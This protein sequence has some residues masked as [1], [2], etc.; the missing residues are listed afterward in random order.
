MF[1]EETRL[2]KMAEPKRKR[3]YNLSFGNTLHWSSNEDS[4]AKVKLTNSEKSK[5]LHQDTEYREK[6]LEG[7]KNRKKPEYTEESK[8]KKRQKM[9]KTMAEKFPIDNRISYESRAG[10]PEHRAKLG[11]AS[12]RNWESMSDEKKAIR[13]AKISE[14][15]KGLKNRLG[16]SNSLEHRQKISE[17]QKGKVLSEEH[18]KKIS[19]AH[20]GRVWSEDRKAKHS[21]TIQKM[22]ENK[23]LGMASILS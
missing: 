17:S 13:S 5:A 18:R 20:K 21:L 15:N 1:N 6:Y 19:K 9:V 16:H 4:K 7:I 14:S 3:Y 10:S 2:L 22:W 11:V 23:K 8:E 12:K